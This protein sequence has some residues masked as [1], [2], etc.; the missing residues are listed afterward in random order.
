MVC[1]YIKLKKK[2]NTISICVSNHFFYSHSPSWIFARRKSFLNEPSPTGILPSLW[3][4]DNL[5]EVG[6]LYD[7][8]LLLLFDR[9]LVATFGF[10]THSHMPFKFISDLVI[11]ELVWFKIYYGIQ[12]AQT[13]YSL[14]WLFLF[15]K[16]IL[17]RFLVTNQTT[18]QI[19]TTKLKWLKKN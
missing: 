5:L 18:N 15:K 13:C 12:C 6:Q 16:C 2:I 9:F 19:T 7:F 11:S 3:R 17:V 4:G 8:L 1:N 14:L 10:S